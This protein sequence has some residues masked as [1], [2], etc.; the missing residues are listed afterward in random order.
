MRPGKWNW[1]GARDGFLLALG[2][3]CLLSFLAGVLFLVFV[4]GTIVSP[5]LLGALAHFWVRAAAL[6]LLTV[7][8]LG[9]VL[10]GFQHR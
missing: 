2:V 9:A 3:I 5:L 1:H 6:S 8:C 7:L 4:L 10:G